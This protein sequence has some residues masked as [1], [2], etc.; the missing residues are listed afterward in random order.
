MEFFNDIGQLRSVAAV[1]GLALL[2]SAEWWMP[3]RAGLQAKVRHAATNLAI[4]G[5]NAVIVTL[6]FGGLL[7]VWSREVESKQWG[8][9]HYLNLSVVPAIIAAVVILDFV[10]Y[11]VHWANHRVPIL[12]RF[13]RAHHSDLD[14]DVTS[15]LRFH[16]GEVL[17]STGIKAICIPL[18]GITWPS[19]VM[20]EMTLQA[21]AQFQH[22]NVRL[23]ESWERKMRMLIVTPHMHWSHHSRFPEDHNRNFGTILSV[24]D[25]ALRTFALRLPRAEI[26]LGLDDYPLP[27]DTGIMRFYLMPFG[28]GCRP[29]PYGL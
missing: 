18:L 12:W 1:S 19:L 17:I 8:V 16:L 21:A 2:L 20:F 15:A 26:R 24:W 27:K 28:R 4:A 14:L 25:R 23:P 22:S 3:F 13:H 9:L 5:S 10:F 11:L 6:L 7:L 29:G